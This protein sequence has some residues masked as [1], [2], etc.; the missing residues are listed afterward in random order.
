MDTDNSAIPRYFEDYYPGETREFGAITIDET[1]MV[2][3]A[4]RYDP[5]SF[6]V[7]REAASDSTFGG[8]IA[9]GWYSA[10]VMMRMMVDHYISP[11][12]GLGSP[13]IQELKWLIPVR[14]GDR[15]HVKVKVL[16]SRISQSKPDRGL[17]R[18][19]VELVRS[20]EEVVMSMI[21]VGMVL[22]RK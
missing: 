7:D 13:G 10:S 11:V 9:S 6:H 22:R 15:L 1:E 21:S 8:I 19:K 14:A 18:S 17:I 12:A 4:K 20:D 3:F 16:D 5:Q 2:E